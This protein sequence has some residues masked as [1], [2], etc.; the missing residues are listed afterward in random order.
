V[1]LISAA[2]RLRSSAATRLTRLG[3]SFEVRVLAS[4]AALCALKRLQIASTFP[5]RTASGVAAPVLAATPLLVAVVEPAR[6]AVV[7]D[8]P[9]PR[10][11]HRRDR[12]RGQPCV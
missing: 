2:S 6:V 11:E 5:I 9:H 12:N 3:N 8:F 7:D 10:G 1:S 4:V